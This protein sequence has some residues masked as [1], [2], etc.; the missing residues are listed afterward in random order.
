MLRS[1]LDVKKIQLFGDFSWE[2]GGTLPQNR[3]W[4]ASLLTL[5]YY[6]LDLT[7]DFHYL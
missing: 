3:L 4:M 5:H 6:C 7:P 2:G 1:S